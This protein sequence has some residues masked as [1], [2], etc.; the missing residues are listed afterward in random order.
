MIGGF[1]QTFRSLF[2]MA[3]KGN[4]IGVRWIL[5]KKKR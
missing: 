3:G 1:R 2:D 4:L 5:L